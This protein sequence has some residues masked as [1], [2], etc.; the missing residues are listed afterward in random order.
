MRKPVRKTHEGSGRPFTPA[1]GLT[2]E[3][4]VGLSSHVLQG[5]PGQL[6]EPQTEG[7][8]ELQAASFPSK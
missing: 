8:L 3:G 4:I 5:G 2:Q 7:H 6:S 1:S